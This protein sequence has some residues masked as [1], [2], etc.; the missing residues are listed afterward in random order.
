MNELAMFPGGAAALSD[1]RRDSD[2]R[3]VIGGDMAETMSLSARQIWQVI[4]RH[5]KLLAIVVGASVLLALVSQLM[6]T[7][8]Y[9]SVALVQVEL[10]ETA[11]AR[12]DEVA[13]RDQLRVA[14]EARTYRSRSLAEKVVRDMGLVHNRSFMGASVVPKGQSSAAA[15]D[16]ATTRLQNM[17]EISSQTGSD[18]IDIAVRTRSPHLSADIANQYVASLRAR[19]LHQR[20]QRKVELAGALDTEVTRLA[21]QAKLAD[22]RVAEFRR[23]HDMPTGAGGEEDY[24]QFNRIEVEAASANG[25]RAADAAR[26]V[27]DSRAAAM[28]TTAG[29]TSSL[30]DQQQ[31]QYDAL[32][33]QRSSLAVTFGDG[34][35][36]IQ[37]IDAQLARLKTDMN[38]ERARVMA[39]EHARIAADTARDQTLAQS[40]AAAAAARASQLAGQL[41]QLK[42]RIESNTQNTPE[43]AELQRQADIAHQAYAAVAQR[44]E[45]VKAGLDSGGVNSWLV[46]PA[47]ASDLPISPQPKRT[48]AAA[49]IGSS[50]LGLLLVYLVE[51]FD[52]KL[53][54][55][56]QV[57]R[58]FRL[59]TFGMFP[60]I[61]GASARSPEESPVLLDPQSLFAE[62]ARSLHAEVAQLPHEGP[63]QSILVTSPLPGDGKSTVALSLV[64]AASAMGRRAVVVDLD[65]RRP[66]LLQDI[67]REIEGPDLV[68]YLTGTA[69]MRKLLPS[70]AASGEREIDTYKPVVISTREPVRDP[71]SLI[72]VGRLRSLAAELR[73]RFDLVIINAPA[74]LAV[75]D[76]RTLTDI[77]DATLVVLSWGKTTIE[78]MRATHQLLQGKIDA[79]VFNQVDYAEHARRGYGDAVQFYVDSSA[80]YTG[81]IPRR[82][83]FGEWLRGLVGRPAPADA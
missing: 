26:S 31:R 68:D 10:N 37:R 33:T 46:S 61:A 28:R 69:D 49:F 39:D 54:T 64:A 3:R 53:R 24:A 45:T 43:L 76:A 17:V 4:R 36:D 65:L 41:A 82:R 38:A 19:R 55:S 75:R 13:A 35:P 25:M 77:A 2:D 51:L 60:E 73:E 83:S 78:Q 79:V 22:D 56:E 66:G 27:G 62:V 23:I 57:R 34:H 63:T 71:A 44:T 67:Q 58:L 70:S 16:H 30:L 7:P 1:D 47:V 40:V 14:N 29:A 80:Y 42:Q 72:R 5:W 12:Q 15:I 18:F 52:N 74:T 59:P 32:T 8:V 20:Q 50:M 48:V 81:P 11:D 9:E 21:A 6:A